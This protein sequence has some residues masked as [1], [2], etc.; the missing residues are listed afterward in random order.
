M[1]NYLLVLSDGTR[2]ENIDLDEV[3]RIL[4]DDCG[5]S[6]ARVK[7]MVDKL[8]CPSEEQ[9]LLSR[10]NRL[11]EWIEDVTEE[12][13]RLSGNLDMEF[14]R[15]HSSGKSTWDASADSA[16]ESAGPFLPKAHTTAVSKPEGQ[17]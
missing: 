9:E 4:I 13:H 8:A 1:S 5:W 12:I 15:C 7:S 3:R 17:P 10:A 2:H 14:K 16:V 11:C 6:Y